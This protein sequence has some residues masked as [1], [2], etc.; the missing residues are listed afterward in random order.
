M[1]H[2]QN[3]QPLPVVPSSPNR[4]EHR[5]PLHQSQRAR[6]TCG[7]P[8]LEPE[9]QAWAAAITLFRSTSTKA[10]AANKEALQTSWGGGTGGAAP[11]PHAARACGAMVPDGAPTW[12]ARTSF[13]SSRWRLCHTRKL[14]PTFHTSRWK[15]E[16]LMRRRR[17]LSPQ[18]LSK[19]Q[20]EVEQRQQQVAIPHLHPM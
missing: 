5:V 19:N 17:R 20:D 2:R 12:P 18:L 8:V 16:C 9:K 6:N 4:E 15:R 10:A 1:E 14:N 13:S 3:R 11:P 7:P